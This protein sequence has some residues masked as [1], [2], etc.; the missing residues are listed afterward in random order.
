MF[1]EKPWNCQ[2]KKS[3]CWWTYFPSHTLDNQTK[4]IPWVK[5][6]DGFQRFWTLKKFVQNVNNVCKARPFGAVVLPTLK[7]E[8]VDSGWAVH[9]SR[10]PETL[11][12]SLHDLRKWTRESLALR[13]V[14]DQQFEQAAAQSTFVC[15]MLTFRS[16]EAGKK[17][18]AANQASFSHHI[19]DT[20]RNNQSPQP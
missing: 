2:R 17:L 1:L 5:V 20:D 19:P 6:S 10:K 18:H 8:L 4:S 14:Y 9:W 11:I 12:D 3:H 13:N 15:L 7:H 16:A